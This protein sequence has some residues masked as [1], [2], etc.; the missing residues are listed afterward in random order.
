MRTR[1]SPLSGHITFGHLIK[2]MPV[3]RLYCEIIN[4]YAIINMDFVGRYFGAVWIGSSLSNVYPPVLSFIQGSNMNLLL[5][6]SS[7]DSWTQSLLFHCLLALY[8][9][10]LADL[11][12]FCVSVWIHGLLFNQCMANRNYS[13]VEI[14]P[15][16][17]W[18]FCCFSSLPGMLLCHVSIAF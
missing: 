12:E 7:G 2:V 13:D 17:S 4:D 5:L 15:N 10:R 18:E 16:S 14:V 11:I 8:P 6:L 9:Y 1:I 3:R